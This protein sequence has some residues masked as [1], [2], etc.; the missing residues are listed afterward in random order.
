MRIVYARGK[1]ETHPDFSVP[2]SVNNCGYYRD[3]TEDLGVLRKNGR[4]DYQIIFVRRGIFVCGGKKYSDGAVFVFRPGEKQEYV[5]KAEPKC[6][7]YWVHFSGTESDNLAAK[8]ALGGTYRK[9]GD[10][11]QMETLFL[12]MADAFVNNLK[13]KELYAAGALL[14]LAALISSPDE[15]ATP[16]RRAEEQIKDLSKPLS[17]S[18]LAD[19][20]NLSTAHFIR[21]FKIYSGM[22]PLSFRQKYQLEQAKNLLSGSDLSIGAI[23][24]ACGFQDPLYFSRIFKKHAGVSPKFFRETY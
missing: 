20:F 6:C 4:S 22:T 13:E 2:L 19:S 21:S 11:S 12:N 15:K 9:N 18:A 1:A 14:S 17:V 16:F 7:Y 8:L 5:Y 24:E 10:A 3:I 23:A